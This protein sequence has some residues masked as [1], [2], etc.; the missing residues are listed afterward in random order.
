M[1][2]YVFQT[3]ANSRSYYR[4]PSLG[5]L[6]VMI[7]EKSRNDMHGHMTAMNYSRLGDLFLSLFDPIDFSIEWD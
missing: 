6:H 2:S 4:D 3:I 7:I 5:M 1:I